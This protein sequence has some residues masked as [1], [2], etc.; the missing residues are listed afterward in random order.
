MNN[1]Q[2]PERVG[3]LTLPLLANYGG[4]LQTAA[5]QE[6]IRKLGGTPINISYALPSVL[7]T[8]HIQG[9]AKKFLLS[10]MLRLGFF[11]LIFNLYNCRW[12]SL[13]CARVFGKLG[14]RSL[15]RARKGARQRSFIQRYIKQTPYCSPYRLSKLIRKHNIT[16][17]VAGSDQ[18]WRYGYVP[19]KRLF[20]C[21]FAPAEVRKNSISYA[22]S[23]GVD[24]WEWPA[25]L[26]ETCRPL[27]Q[28]FKAHSVREESG[29][30][31]CRQNLEVE[32]QWMPDPTFLLSKAD[33]LEIIAQSNLP[34]VEKPAAYIAY[35]I[36][37][38]T[39]E[40]RQCLDQL[41]WTTGLPLVNCMYENPE[42]EA[43][44]SYYRPIE[45]WLNLIESARYMVT[46]SFHGSV[47]SIIFNTDF[48]CF[49]NKDR[50][51]SRFDSLLG[52]LNLSHRLI[53][54][55]TITLQATADTPWKSVNDTLR[56]WQ[57]KGQSFLKNNLNL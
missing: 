20:F 7:N 51:N 21:S 15:M 32:A 4:L 1:T 10:I 13:N 37:D 25:D 28:D 30:E 31:L 36:L 35:Y 49:G 42:A 2:Q 19:D 48:F 55:D 43:D 57:Q 27:A 54:S 11:E 14:L 18:V 38:M 12:I 33:Y 16:A 8:W 45:H 44:K 3:I 23:Y 24:T 40:K 29:V 56:S 39:P 5:L 53:Q 6:C 17:C 41:S 46:D 22:A 47:F 26:T 34:P 9:K 52:K 50:G